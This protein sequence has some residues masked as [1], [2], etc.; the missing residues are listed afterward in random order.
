MWFI[1]TLFLYSYMSFLYVTWSR[2]LLKLYSATS[3]KAITTK[4]GGNTYKNEILAYLHM[5][6]PNHAKVIK[7]T[8]PKVVLMKGTYLNRPCDFWLYGILTD[9]KSICYF[10]KNCYWSNLIAK[11]HKLIHLFFRFNI[12]MINA[13]S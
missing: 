4:L 2:N 13:A 6:W 1:I 10:Y 8:A 11:K 9:E 7:A 5:T 3:K 12:Y